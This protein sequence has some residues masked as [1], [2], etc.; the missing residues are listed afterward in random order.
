M[1]AWGTI[2]RMIINLFSNLAIRLRPRPEFAKVQSEA[3][4]TPAHLS[5]QLQCRFDV[6]VSFRE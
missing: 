1:L 2:R 3:N 6:L 4:M 5:Q